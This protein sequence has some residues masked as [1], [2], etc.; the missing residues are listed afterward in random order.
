MLNNQSI[1]LVNEVERLDT[2]TF[3]TISEL[4]LMYNV[5]SDYIINLFLEI[6]KIKSIRNKDFLNPEVILLII[7]DKLSSLLTDY[8][9]YSNMKDTLILDDELLEIV[10]KELE[11]IN[12][13]IN[14]YKNILGLNEQKKAALHR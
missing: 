1:H 13:K 14:M 5:S 12:Y 9:Y 10:N 8:E 11:E 4:E 7:E 2:I 3:E 6:Q